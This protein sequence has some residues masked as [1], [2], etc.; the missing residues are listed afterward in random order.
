M[1]AERVCY[2]KQMWTDAFLDVLRVYVTVAAV[3]IA[4]EDKYEFRP[5]ERRAH[6]KT[7]GQIRTKDQKDL[8]KMD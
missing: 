6:L 2:R 1:T 5:M 4:N 7:K 8:N 3:V